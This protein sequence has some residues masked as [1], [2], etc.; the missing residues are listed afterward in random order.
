MLART[1]FGTRDDK[2][3]WSRSGGACQHAP[4]GWLRTRIERPF[5]IDA[6]VVLPEHRHCVCGLPEGDADFSTRWRVIKARFAR[7]MPPVA[8]RE[9]L[10]RR[11]EH[12]VWQR[13]ICEHRMRDAEDR[14]SP[15]RTC[16]VKPVKHGFVE[17]PRECP[18]SS[19]HRDNP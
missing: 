6:W 4:Y 11:R 9:S 16:W 13:R 5:G 14:D 15:I 8:R 10:R 2:R 18:Y 19:W 1:D 3:R 7:A 17:H 12:G